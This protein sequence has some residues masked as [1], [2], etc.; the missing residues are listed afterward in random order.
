MAIILSLYV[1]SWS[2]LI[3]SEYGR[4]FKKHHLF[5]K[6]L[7][8]FVFLIMTGYSLLHFQGS[9]NSVYIVLMCLGMLFCFLG[10][11]FLSV[12]KNGADSKWFLLGAG[13]FM[14]AHGMFFFALCA[15]VPLS[16]VDVLII[17]LITVGIY[18]LS[19]LPGMNVKGKRPLV[20]TYALF[21][22]LLLS[23]AISLLTFFGA[24]PFTLA[25]LIG[26]ILF[27]A[28]DIILLFELFR[29]KKVFI[30][31]MINLFLYYSAT[32]LL[33]ISIGL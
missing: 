18:S 24:T 20:L 23:K 15:L 26:A 17:L 7:T 3:G 16:L 22:G 14:G 29:S 1:V 5:F 25:V 11:V 32:M 27:T 4:R 13:F 6:G 8:S 19:S 12:K 9:R 10:D 28:S 31:P 33:A 30:L 21:L 2:L